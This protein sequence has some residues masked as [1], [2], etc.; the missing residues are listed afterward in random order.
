MK[1]VITRTQPDEMLVAEKRKLEKIM[2]AILHEL[3]FVKNNE[4]PRPRW[5]RWS[6]RF[7]CAFR[8]AVYAD[9]GGY[10][11]LACSFRRESGGY[12]DIVGA[13]PFSGKFNCHLFERVTAEQAAAQWRRWIEYACVA[14]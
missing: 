5:T 10:P 1:T 2:P 14:P 9:Y 6:V 4:C 11:W 12:K 13:N 7:N 8:V 3:G